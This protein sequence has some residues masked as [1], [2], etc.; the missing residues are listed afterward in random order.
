M[1]LHLTC[2]AKNKNVNGC[3]FHTNIFQHYDNNRHNVVN[4][5]SCSNAFN[6]LSLFSTWDLKI[7]LYKKDY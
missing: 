3:Y 4:S 5:I 7:V 1:F 2:G 6:E